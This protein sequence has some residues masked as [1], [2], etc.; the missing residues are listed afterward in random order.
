[1]AA[2]AGL[3]LNKVGSGYTLQVS[4][5]GLSAAVT[6]A[7]AVTKASGMSMLS[8]TAGTNVP[9]ALLAPLVIDSPDSLDTGGLKK[10]TPSI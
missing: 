4:S 2:F 9:D 6:S 5:N 7:I 8:A 3:T 1:M 10:R